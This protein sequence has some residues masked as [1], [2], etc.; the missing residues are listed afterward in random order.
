MLPATSAI[1]TGST[2][3]NSTAALPDV[4]LGSSR[5]ADHSL[6]II[7]E[8]SL[9]HHHPIRFL[10]HNGICHSAGPRKSGQY[11]GVRAVCSGGVVRETPYVHDIS[12]R[13]EAF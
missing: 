7:P 4:L 13:N 11:A 2:I 12:D 6:R 9:R 1:S 3:A 5:A 8:A 10:R